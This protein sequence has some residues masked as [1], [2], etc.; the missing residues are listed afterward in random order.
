MPLPPP[1]FQPDRQRAGFPLNGGMSWTMS[2]AP[3][4]PAWIFPF[5]RMI[6]QTTFMPHGQM[7]DPSIDR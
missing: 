7:T 3:S 5:S 4:L 2:S 1:R 6:L